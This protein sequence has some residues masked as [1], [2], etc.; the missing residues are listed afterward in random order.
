M[1]RFRIP[2]YSSV[3]PPQEYRVLGD[4]MKAARIA[5]GYYQHQAAAEIGIHPTHISQIENAHRQ[6]SVFELDALARVYNVSTD[7]LI[8]G[9]EDPAIVGMPFAVRAIAAELASLPEEAQERLLRSVRALV[10]AER[11]ASAS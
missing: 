4:R 10:R 8:R 11:E 2:K 5:A 1:A 3:R 6:V 7:S 9:V